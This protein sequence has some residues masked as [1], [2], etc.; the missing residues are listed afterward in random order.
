MIQVALFVLVNLFF[1]GLGTRGHKQ[2]IRL[3]INCVRTNKLDCY[4]RLKVVYGKMMQAAPHQLWAG[5]I[6]R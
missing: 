2:P 6:R 1:H 3:A 5:V 4:G